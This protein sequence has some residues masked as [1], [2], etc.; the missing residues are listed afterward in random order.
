MTKSKLNA[1]VRLARMDKPIGSYLLLWPTLWALLIAG[2]GNPPIE[3]VIVFVA[4][5]FAMRSA[6]CVI[7]DYADRHVDG[8]VERTK[9]RP[10]VSGEV[11]EKEALLFF[12]ALVFISFLLVLTLNYQTILLSFGALALA[13]IYPF[14]KRFTNLPQVVL[15]AAFSW[16][17]PMAFMAVNEQIHWVGWVLFVINV[18]WTVGYD[19]E[20][21]MVDRDDD[22]QI[23]IKSTA[24]LF[25]QADKLAIGITQ[26]ITLLLLSFVAYFLNMTWP[27]Y[28]SLL[29]MG[30]LFIYQQYLI[31][32]RVRANCF[33]AFLNNHYAG[34]IVA[35]GMLCHYWL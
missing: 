32:D 14:M 13:T 4:G 7:N 17:I 2:Q 23:G 28:L 22:L 34:M 16:A 9:S 6:G 30:G 8:K 33:Q 21:A 31:K 11:T 24:V 26:L 35:I 3:I 20:Y 19:T 18:I 15:G 25:A 27:V 1:F 12:S 29:A 10:L 5:V